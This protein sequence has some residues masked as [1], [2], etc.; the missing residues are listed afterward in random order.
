[1]DTGAIVMVSI[2]VILLVMLTALFIWL[3]SGWMDPGIGMVAF[4]IGAVFLFFAFGWVL[5]IVI[6]F[7]CSIIAGFLFMG[8]E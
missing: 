1:M 8:G 5:I 3:T 6:A 7:V 2:S 4:G